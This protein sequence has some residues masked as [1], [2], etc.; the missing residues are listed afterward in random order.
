MD[1]VKNAELGCCQLCPFSITGQFLFC[2]DFFPLPLRVLPDPGISSIVEG[3][4]GDRLPSRGSDSFSHSYLAEGTTALHGTVTPHPQ[5]PPGPA[6]PLLTQFLVWLPQLAGTL[7]RGQI[8]LRI[9]GG[10]GSEN[11]P[12][13][14]L[15]ASQK[16]LGS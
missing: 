12:A 1:A 2:F 11:S 15:F 13:Q 3:R 7:V 9:R 5:L 14:P 8:G 16:D 10:G 4:P 6:S